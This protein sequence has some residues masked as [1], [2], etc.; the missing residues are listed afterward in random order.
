MDKGLTNQKMADVELNDGR[1]GSHLSGGAEIQ[2]VASVAFK[3]GF[4]SSL[5]RPYEPGKLN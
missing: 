4:C 2:S 5:R 1:D 3:T